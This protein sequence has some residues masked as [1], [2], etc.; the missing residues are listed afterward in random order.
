MNGAETI[1]EVWR[2][3]CPG[4]RRDQ[5]IIGFVP[6]G[7][8]E[9]DLAEGGAVAFLGDQV[10][11]IT[12]RKGEGFVVQAKSG[13][14]DVSGDEL[15][16]AMPVVVHPEPHCMYFLATDIGDFAA[17]AGRP[18]A[19][20]WASPTYSIELTMERLVLIDADGDRVAFELDGEERRTL[21]AAL[22]GLRRRRTA[23]IPIAPSGMCEVRV[24][25]SHAHLSALIDPTGQIADLFERQGP[26]ATLAALNGL[27][28]KAG[29]SEGLPAG[30]QAADLTVPRYVARQLSAALLRPVT[31][32]N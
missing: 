13:S 12:G 8:V 11:E 4:C 31:M 21:G 9:A 28:V 7:P 30:I 22:G 32:P 5:C 19:S 2:G 10:V 16:W 14:Q 6:Y 20:R 29:P 25:D 26:Q 3:M 23:A 24:T 18:R 15:R 1:Y 17:D 27:A